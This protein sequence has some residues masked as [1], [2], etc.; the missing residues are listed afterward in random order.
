MLKSAVD[1][2]VRYAHPGQLVIL[3]SSVAPGTTREV[4]AESL[5]RAG[6]KP[7]KDV[8]VSFSPERIDPGNINF[9]MR[10]IP[11]VVSGYDAL[12]LELATAFYSQIVNQVIPVTSLEAAELTKILEN[13]FRLVNISFINEIS[14]F[15]RAFGLDIYEVIGA[16]NTKPFGFLPH[17]PGPGAGGYCIPVLP[18]YLLA[19]AK[20][21]GV[22]LPLTTQAAMYNAN[23]PKTIAQIA[24]QKAKQELQSVNSPRILLVGIAYKANEWDTRQSVAVAM[25]NELTRLGAKVDYHDPHVASHKGQ[26][27]LTLT[28][29]IVKEY[30]L[31]VILTAHLKND[32]KILIESGVPVFDTVNAL[33]N[34]K[35]KQIYKL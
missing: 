21:T 19:A 27:S 30:N 10:Q 28:P 25:W 13:T 15:A 18:Y 22:T 12:S 20:N 5:N 24:F 26:N 34:Y 8:F 6:F 3:E 16:A 4:V 32:Y 11:K 2:I 1:T 33:R 7:G 14:D 23:R 9:S 35:A 31:I 29:K 17:Y